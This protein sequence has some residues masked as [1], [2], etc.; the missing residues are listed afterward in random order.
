M[1]QPVHQQSYF[2]RL[3]YSRE[4]IDRR[5]S[6][7]WHTLFE[8][9][10]DERIYFEA[11]PDMGYMLDTGNLDVRTEGQSYGMM[12]AVQMDRQDVFDRIWK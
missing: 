12:M 8:G 6:E 1:E 9:P 10:P 11:G 3:G 4:E 7:A 5:V 2:E